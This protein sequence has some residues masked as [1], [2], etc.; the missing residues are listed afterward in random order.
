MTKKEKKKKK[1]CIEKVPYT[2]VKMMGN[3]IYI[4]LICKCQT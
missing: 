3:N 2:N 4:A 1:K